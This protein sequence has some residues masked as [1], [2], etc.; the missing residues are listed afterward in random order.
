MFPDFPSK[1]TGDESQLIKLLAVQ[2]VIKWILDI[3]A[4]LNTVV[5]R[6][7]RA[8]EQSVTSIKS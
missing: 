7:R 4:H 5:L 6:S 8:L 2:R 1:P 3:A